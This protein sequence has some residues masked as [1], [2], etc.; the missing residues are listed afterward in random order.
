MVAAIDP[1]KDVDGLHPVNIGR[2]WSGL[3]ALVPCTPLGC[4]MLLQD[5]PGGLAGRD[6]VNYWLRF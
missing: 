3:D 1:S 6:A 5:V 4:M 2:L